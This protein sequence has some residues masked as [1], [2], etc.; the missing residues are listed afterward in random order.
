MESKQRRKKKPK[1][2]RAWLWE[3]SKKIVVTCAVLYILSFFYACV[4][5]IYAADYSYLGT[6]IEQATDVLKTCVFGYF[7]KAGIENVFKIKG[8]SAENDNDGVI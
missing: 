8:S 1:S 6:Y 2:K 5:M 7:V 3:F 4:V